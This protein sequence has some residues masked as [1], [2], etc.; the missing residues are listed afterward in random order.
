MK[1]ERLRK[2][3]CAKK[4]KV[5]EFLHSVLILKI[6]KLLQKIYYSFNLLKVITKLILKWVFTYLLISQS[7]CE[8]QRTIYWLLY[9]KII[10][11]FANGELTLM[12]WSAGLK[13]FFSTPSISPLNYWTH[14]PLNPGISSCISCSLN[15]RRAVNQEESNANI[16]A[17]DPYLC[18][19]A[20]Q[21]W[22]WLE[23][24]WFWV[25]QV[26]WLAVALW[27]KAL[28]WWWSVWGLWWPFLWLGSALGLSDALCGLCPL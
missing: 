16:H 28:S 10:T 7:R 12:N 24:L 26:L 20:V 3:R 4:K 13:I 14:D 9:L 19:C 2:I 27:W 23:L 15:F 11:A 21:V 18:P 17:T 6:Q 5:W 8:N 25:L 1:K 22:P